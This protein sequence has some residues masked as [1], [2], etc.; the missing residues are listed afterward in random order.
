MSCHISYILHSGFVLESPDA[1]VV[2][3]LWLC[4]DPDMPLAS[5][6]CFN[7]SVKPVYVLVSHVHP[8]HFN[9]EIINIASV[10][11]ITFLLSS[12]IRRKYKSL[13]SVD[14][15]HWLH[16]GDSFANSILRVQAFGSTDVGVSFLIHV[17]G[18][19]IF[20]AGDFN[21]WQR[22]SAMPVDNMQMHNYFIAELRKMTPDVANADLALFPVDP[23]QEH[24]IALG[25][26]Q[27]CSE[28]HPKALVPM[29]CWQ[30]FDL[31]NAIGSQIEAL[32][33]RFIPLHPG[34]TFCL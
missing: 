21:D 15:I 19:S 12:D 2:V 34:L 18:V 28:T 3:D 29:H 30:Q 14:A 10:Q 4:P 17:G 5:L 32:G 8:D 31:A 9:P 11:P 23:H 13:R 33:T 20:H 25:A 7:Q 16:R 1:I 27:F 6:P 24:F 26:T 22:P